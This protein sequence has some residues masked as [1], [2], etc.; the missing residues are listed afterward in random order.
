MI[1]VKR[2]LI[3]VSD[4]TG[5]ADFARFLAVDQ[6][7][8]VI[9]TGGTLKALKDAGIPAV[10]IE[11]Y[12]GFPEMMDGRVKTLHPKIHGGLLALRD[13]PEHAKAMTDNDIPGIDLVVVNLYPFAA[14]VAKPDVSFEDAIEN[15][16]I[17]GPTMLRAAA[18]NY[19]FTAVVSDPADYEMIQ[20]T[21]AGGGGI[22]PEISLQLAR[23]VFNHTAAYDAMIS[24]YLNDQAEDRFPERLT[25]TY[26]K[27]Q[28]LRYGE[29]PHQAACYYRPAID[30]AREK[31]GGLDGIE[32][33]QG[34]ELSYNNLLD[35][36]AALRA[37]LSLP[38]PGAVIVKHLNPC[39]V[40]VVKDADAKIGGSLKAG[41]LN[42][43]F[44]RA[45]AC[46]PVSAFGGIIA[47]AGAVDGATAESI[48]ENFAEVIVAPEF[49]R[50]ALEIFGKKKN[51]RLLRIA[52]AER[53]LYEDA[54]RSRNPREAR[55]IM[56]G[57]LY[58]DLDTRIASRDE[59]QIVTEV[60]PDEATLRA[61]DFAWRV[62]KHVKSNAI[63]FTAETETLAIGAG[64]MSRIDSVE[65]AASKAKKAG[66]ALKGSVV[67]SDAFFPFRDGLDAL[68]NAGARA[69]IQPGGS[70]RDEE[71][72]AA[73]NEHGVAMVFT[74]MRHFLH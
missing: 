35:F 55:Q 19:G 53:Y 43:A 28:S 33:L 42:D 34:K 25:L 38:R 61:L 37:A 52:D 63:V 30:V 4:K 60:Q 14:T 71:V 39:G 54:R 27:N 59:W 2:A 22:S 9:S 15:I 68:A 50:E 8:E 12:T 69:V 20:K 51:L 1:Q 44:V 16:D 6:K 7:V 40:A 41:D 47:L 56:G 57:L 17:G 58:Q 49:S 10:A 64:Q 29:N 13:N 65:I 3:S 24:G 74:G 46:D 73:A 11:D 26:E 62:C 23:K 21:I 70:V 48:A 36:N 66:L 32:Q 67:A 31:H 45:R 72:I 5:L 18:K